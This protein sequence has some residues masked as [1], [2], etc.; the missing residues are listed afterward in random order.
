MFYIHPWV[1]I[2]TTR[3]S[4]LWVDQTPQKV[5]KSVGCTG[6]A[7]LKEGTVIK[8]KFYTSVTL[9]QNL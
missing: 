5:E 2:H 4:S 3:N 6:I 7:T 8:Y 1:Y 9:Q